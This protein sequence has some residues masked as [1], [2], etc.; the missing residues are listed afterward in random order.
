[1]SSI[2]IVPIWQRE[3]HNLEFLRVRISEVFKKKTVIYDSKKI[4]LNG[5]YNPSRKQYNS[6]QI[7]IQLLNNH[8]RDTFRI[9]GVT[10]V[11]LFIPILTFVFGEAQLNGKG[12]IVSLHRLQNKFYGLPEN[13]NLVKERLIKEAI[14]ELGHTYG[15]IHCLYPGCV[16]NSSTYVEDID[17]K[18]DTFC[19]SCLD[20]LEIG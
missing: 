10:D 19:P 3:N 6:S 9:I 14:H 5:T 8:P 1:M 2:Y 11:D 20:Y 15:L 17:Q 4:D 18:G 16:M 7:L 12:A 13:D